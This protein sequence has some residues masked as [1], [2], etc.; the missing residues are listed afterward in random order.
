MFKQN[1]VEKDNLETEPN[2]FY[3]FDRYILTFD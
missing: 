3:L 2:N 1:N